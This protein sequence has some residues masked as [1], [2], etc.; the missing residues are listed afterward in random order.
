MISRRA[1][2]RRG[3][4][5]RRAPVAAAG[6]RRWID[7]FI[8][9]ASNACLVDDVNIGDGVSEYVYDA[10]GR[11]IEKRSGGVATRYL[12]DGA[13]VAE[14]WDVPA[15][16]SPALAASYV[17]G[18]Y[19]DEVLTMRRG[20]VDYYYHADDQ[21]NVVKLTDNAGAVVEA[22]DYA[23]YGLPE[24]FDAAGARLE[25]TASQ[26]ANP[27]PSPTPSTRNCYLLPQPLLDPPTGVRQ[28]RPL[29]LW[30][31]AELA[32]HTYAASNPWS[33]V[34]PMGLEA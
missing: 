22:Y 20:G 26:F 25:V 31:P 2:M 5:T 29:G 18:N 17:Y 8:L 16:G 15:A 23:D 9:E 28:P 32:T 27:Y 34:D 11:R 3:S 33:L 21:H 30:A 7:R 1:S 10:L 4:T 13:R 12:H 24:F 19:I 14:E 6:A